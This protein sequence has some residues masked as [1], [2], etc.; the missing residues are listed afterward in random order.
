MHAFA[1]FHD[2]VM[3]DAAS[4]RG[5]PTTHAV[6][7]GRAR[8]GAA[9]PASR[10]GSAR[11]WRSSSATS[12]SCYADQLMLGAPVDGVAD[13]ERAAHRAQRRPVPRHP[14][15]GAGERATSPRPSGSARYKSGKYTIER[16]LHLGAVLAA[17]DRAA[18]L[19]PGAQRLRAAAR[20]RLPDARRRDRRVRR[21]APSPASRSAATSAR[22]SRRRCSPAPWPPPTPSQLAV[23]DRVGAADLD[24]G[25]VAD[26]P[27]GHR[28]HRRARRR[29]RQHIAALTARGDR[30][31]RRDRARRRRDGRADRARRL[32][33]GRVI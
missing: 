18:R 33:V 8:G 27:A 9:G 29:S 30:R 12:P 3:D 6:Y 13:L 24:D 21:R 19:L 10:A 15:L 23:L 5:A 22:A 2:D 11:A 1:L 14:R 32:L 28:R 25:E 16:P 17:P 26:D 4:R 7:A 31:P 20:R